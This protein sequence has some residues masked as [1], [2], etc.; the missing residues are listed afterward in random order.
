MFGRGGPWDWDLEAA[1]Q[2][3]SF[4]SADIRAWTLA[5]EVGYIFADVLGRP[6]LGLR[7]D[8]G[9]G[10]GNLRDGRVG[11]FVVLFP[12]LSYISNAAWFAPSNIKGLYP[13]LTVEPHADLR[14]GFDYAALWRHREADAF[15]LSPGIDVR[16]TAGSGRFIG[17]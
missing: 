10:D 4:G 1:Y 7:A 17:H 16:G 2:F 9:S 3:G 5:N 13:T 12:K 14:I 11:A 8:I 6:R 15:Y